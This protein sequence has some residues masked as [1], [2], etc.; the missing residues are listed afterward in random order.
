MNSGNSGGGQWMAAGLVPLPILEFPD[1]ASRILADP[2]VSERSRTCG[3]DGCKAEVGQSYAGQPALSEG[4][5]PTCG[6]PFSFLPKLRKGDLVAGQYEVVG[7]LARGGLG[8]VYLA[9][10]T[11]LDDNFVAL[12]GLI[13]T[14]D[15]QALALAVSERRFLIALDHPNVVRI[16]NF[17][18][19]PD[20]HSG[21]HIGYIVMEYVNGDS[22]ADIKA[23]VVQRPYTPHGPLLVEHVIAYGCEILA[24]FEYLHGH[25]LLYCDMKPS[26]VIKSSDRIKIIDL[27]A[28]RGIDDRE[29]PVVGTLHYQV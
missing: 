22:L 3:K 10:D 28:V 25:G 19:H 27:G 8:W 18:T 1:P 26:N 12:K 16:F 2:K 7:C 17:V 23:M 6:H 20:P 15:A 14:N 4:Y 29:A 5:C 24:A 13:N 21:E 11:H 9:K